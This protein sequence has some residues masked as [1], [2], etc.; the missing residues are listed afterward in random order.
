[1]KSRIH[2]LLVVLALG[3]ATRTA[4]AQG[5][6]SAHWRSTVTVEGARAGQIFQDAEIWM[7]GTSMKIEER[8]KTSARTEVLFLGDEAYFWVEGQSVGS[9]MGAALAARRGGASHDYAR[10]SEEIRVRGKK[11]RSEELDGQPCEVFEYESPQGKGTYWLATKL[12]N[13]P[14]KAIVERRLS[15]PYRA[16]VDRPIRMEYRNTELRIPAKGSEEKLALPEGVE[17]QDVTELVLGGR[18]PRRPGA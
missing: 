11:I 17:F 5:V 2:R 13:F 3:I 14:I 4:L 7:A 12:R 1:M 16:Q 15:L 18:P 9:K 10:R 8:G 6:S